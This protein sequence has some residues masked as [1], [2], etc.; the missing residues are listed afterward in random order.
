MSESFATPVNV[1]K[2]QQVASA[3]RERGFE[4]EIMDSPDSALTRLQE[5]IPSGARVMTGS[6]TTLKQIGFMEYLV[7]G[8]HQWNDV[9][10]EIQQEDDDVKRADL[11]RKAVT[12]DYF[13]ASANAITESG[14]IVSADS[15]GSRVGA[16]LYAAKHL[17]LVVSAQKIVPDIETAM[18]R[19]REYVFPKED[20]R[21][22]EAYGAGSAVNKWAIVEGEK[23]P[24]R[25]KVLLLPQSL[26]F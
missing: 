9:H 7:S 8:N 16:Y 24:G 6:S 25:I 10:L 26:G 5:I 22:L 20:K 13:V 3:M 15:T 12:A 4:V 2:L 21:A 23:V 11:R 14:Q 18:Q 1:E 17:V 19:I